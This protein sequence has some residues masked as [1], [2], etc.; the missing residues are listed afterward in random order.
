MGR[1]T[2]STTAINNLALLLGTVS[3]GF[4]VTSFGIVNVY[5]ALGIMVLIIAI[6]SKILLSGPMHVDTSNF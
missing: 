5:I 6:I 4:L 2:G 1:V 3:S